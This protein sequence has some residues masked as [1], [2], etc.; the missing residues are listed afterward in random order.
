LSA[1]FTLDATPPFRLDLTVWALRRR[2]A[3]AVDRWDGGVYRRAL[4][5]GSGAI[6]EAEVRQLAPTDAARVLVSVT[7]NRLDRNTRAE[8]A[9]A[10]RQ[11]LGL[12]VDLRDF[13]DQLES[14]SVLRPLVQR[15]RGLKP[16]RFPSLFECLVNAIACQQLT[17]SVG[18]ALLNRLAERYGR[19]AADSSATALHTFPDPLDLATADIEAVRG[20][21]FSTAKA[22]ALVDLAQHINQRDLDL[23]HQVVGDDDAASAALQHLRGIGRWSAVYALLR[24]MGRIAVFPGDDVGARNNLKRLLGVD[25]DN[26]E[27]VRRTASRWAPYAGLVYF[28]MLLEHV[29][30]SGWLTDRA[31]PAPDN[32]SRSDDHLQ[33]KGRS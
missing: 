22:R 17:L 33:R 30:R 18:I 20:L 8:T 19:T 23:D 9:A 24:G 6:A 29:E 13:Y 12:D 1:H 16:P 25:V 10:L 5:L 3:N 32:T 7:T 2:P 26:Y 21:G 14:D 28:H 15:F 27:A 11:M 31:A 4:R